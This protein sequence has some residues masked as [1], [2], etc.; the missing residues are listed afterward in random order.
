MSM[1]KTWAANYSLPQLV[2]GDFQADPDQ[3]ASTQGMA[4]NFVESFAVIGSGSRFTFS[5][6]NPTMKL[7]YWFF[8]RSWTTQPLSSEVSTST[9]SESD[10]M[11]VRATFLIQ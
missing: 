8:D 5:L 6:P 4:P 10:H 1:L 11:P 3:I 7:D 9:G 2:A